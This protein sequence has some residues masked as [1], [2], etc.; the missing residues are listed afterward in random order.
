MILPGAK[1]PAFQLPALTGENW[2]LADALRQGPLVL[3]F[4][5]IA[6]PTCQFTLPFLNRMATAA[7]G[8][9]RVVGISQDDA[10]GTAQFLERFAPGLPTLLDS[11]G[12]YLTSKAFG[13]THVPS[14]FIVEQDGT[15]AGAADGFHKQMMEDLGVRG[16]VPAFL[17]GE[18]VPEMRPG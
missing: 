10:S 12:G 8:S 14:V 2:A 15:I 11:E 9:L 4:F 3:A 1:A 17:P 5:K 6:C 18:Q 16:G 7:G 13:I